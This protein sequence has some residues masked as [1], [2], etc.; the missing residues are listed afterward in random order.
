MKITVKKQVLVECL[1]NVNNLIDANNINPVLSGV[2]IKTLNNKLIIIATNG[3]SSY[4]QTIEDGDI[5]EDGNILVRARFFYNI[6]SKIDQEEI[7]LNQIDDGILQIKTPKFS[8]EINLID[9]SSFPII[10]F[11]YN[12]FKKISFDRDTLNNIY[13]RVVPFV[14]VPT[15]NQYDF[16]NALSFAAIDEKEMECVACDSFRVGYCKFNYQGD[17]IKFIIGPEAIRMACDISSSRNNKSVEWYIN[18][19]KCILKIDN[20]LVSFGLYENNYPDITKSLLA[21]QKYHFTVKL[22]DLHNAL[23]RGSVFVSNEKRPAANFKISNNKLLIKFVSSEAG[24]SYEEL[25]ITES[26]IENY[27]V[28]LNQKLFSDLISTI[29]SNTITFNFNGEF[30]PIIIDSENKYFKNL[31]LPLRNL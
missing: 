8:C 7:T 13:E 3:T 26:N 5:K 14:A 24:N 23:S 20:T 17:P 15:H 4:M 30:T 19:K 10:S 1:K 12:G 9:A 11:E 21:P 16:S 6:I 27:E 18:N 22:S 29:S 2:N 25:D 28:K 31:I